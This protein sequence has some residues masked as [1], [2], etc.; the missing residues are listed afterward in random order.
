MS[1]ELK[2]LAVRVDLLSIALQEVCRALAPAQA[3]QVADAVRPWVAHLTNGE[4]AA[5]PRSSSATGSRPQAPHPSAGEDR[6][7]A[8]PVF[9]HRAALPP[10]TRPRKLVQCQ[11]GRCSAIQGVKWAA[12]IPKCWRPGGSPS[13][14]RSARGGCQAGIRFEAP[15][16]FGWAPL[17]DWRTES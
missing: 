4:T 16:P 13:A 17:V 2:A 10:A 3:T 5:G 14:P 9:P 15:K 8:A 7:R 1:D 11:Q 12:R 6:T